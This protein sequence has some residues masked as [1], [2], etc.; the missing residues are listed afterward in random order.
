MNGSELLQ[1]LPGIALTAARYGMAENMA[2]KIHDNEPVGVDMAGFIAADIADGAIMR[3]F[4]MDTPVR[5]A[6]DGIVDHMSV[7]RVAYEIWKKYPDSRQYIGILATRAVIVGALNAVHLVSTGEVTKGR[8]KQKATNLATAAFALMATS[9]NH[10][11]THIAGTVA[12]GIAIIT[13]ASHFK[14]LGQKH[15]SGIRAL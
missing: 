13:A 2:V 15:T 12:S 4:D 7:A 6:T 10:K 1:E 11:A 8:S 3:R 14:D 5:R 9:G